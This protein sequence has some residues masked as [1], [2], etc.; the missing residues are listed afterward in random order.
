[1]SYPVPT[2]EAGRLDAL[3]RYKLIEAPADSFYD[4]MVIVAAAVA[5]VPVAA[6]SL[7]E[8][9]KQFFKSRMGTDITETPRE[10]AFCAYTI[11]GTLPMVVEDATL[12]SRFAGNPLVTND[13]HIRFYAGAPI[14]DPEG[15]ALG[16]L[17][18]I[19]NTPHQLGTRQRLALMALARVIS[20]HIE[21]CQHLHQT[22]Q[23]VAPASSVRN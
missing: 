22:G 17:C 14:I 19:D 12:D 16:S 4:D 23:A 20:K 9:H 2:N 13:P 7:V 18:V 6:V 8:E 5:N 21:V 1:M 10:Q 15:H 3:R 11:L